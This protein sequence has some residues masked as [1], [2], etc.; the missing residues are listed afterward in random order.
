MHSFDADTTRR[1]APR[2][3]AID[4][5]AT[6]AVQAPPATVLPLSQGRGAH[7]LLDDPAGM[8]KLRPPHP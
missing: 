7:E 2:Q 1:R 6:G 4:L 5:M 3:A 8:G